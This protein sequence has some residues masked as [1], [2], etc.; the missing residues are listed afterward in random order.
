MPLEIMPLS[1]IYYAVTFLY[2]M[3]N[4][5]LLTQSG[6]GKLARRT[7]RCLSVLGNNAHLV[8]VPA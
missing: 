6:K 1:R 5:A 4:I 8:F 2:L 3:L 7:L